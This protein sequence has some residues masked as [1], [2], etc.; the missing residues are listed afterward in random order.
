MIERLHV[1]TTGEIAGNPKG[2]AVGHHRGY[3]LRCRMTLEG[4]LGSM[5]YREA[6]APPD[7]WQD[8]EDLCLQ[9]W[10]PRLIDAKKHGRQGQPQAGVDVFGRDPKTGARW[11]VQCKQGCRWAQEDL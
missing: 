10:R 5:D 9:L 4:A 2:A 11:G 7:R 8:F 1:E 3:D 6:K